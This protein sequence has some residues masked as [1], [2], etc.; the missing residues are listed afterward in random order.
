MKELLESA[1]EEILNLRRQNEVLSAKVDTL[2][3]VACLLH[4]R[5]AA[6]DQGY[7][8]DIV[9]EIDKAIRGVKEDEIEPDLKEPIPTGRGVG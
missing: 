8:T 3:F 1:K 4:T 9:W 2:E 6:S 7:G 5:P